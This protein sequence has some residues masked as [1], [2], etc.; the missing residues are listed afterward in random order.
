MWTTE[1]KRPIMTVTGSHYKTCIFGT[2]TIDG[3]QFFRQ[4]DVFNQYAFLK[5]LMELQ[6][7]FRKLLLFL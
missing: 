3:K 4:Y 5:Y 1:G 6:R 2:I 7:K